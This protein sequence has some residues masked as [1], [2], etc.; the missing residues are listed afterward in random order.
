MCCQVQQCQKEAFAISVRNAC[1]GQA[2][3]VVNM[4]LSDGSL[5]M[6]APS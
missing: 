6:G 3:K 1:N 4:L 5:F 2:G